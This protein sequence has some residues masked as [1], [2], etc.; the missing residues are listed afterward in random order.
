M[1]YEIIALGVLVT[2]AAWD[3]ARRALDQRVVNRA[4]HERID[5]LYRQM[6]KEHDQLQAVMGKLNATAAAQ[7]TRMPRTL[8]V[9]R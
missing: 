3:V 7:S 9:S 6:E 5:L 4:L 8:Q 1:S 2:A